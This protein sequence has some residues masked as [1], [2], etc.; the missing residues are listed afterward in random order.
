MAELRPPLARRVIPWVVGLAF[1]IMTA[2]AMWRVVG[3]RESALDR[4]SD[5]LRAF[6]EDYVTTWEQGLIEDLEEAL[7]AVATDPERSA[8]RQNRMRKS[9][10]WF[11]SLYVWHR[12]RRT[13]DGNITEPHFVFPSVSSERS[14]ELVRR[15]CIQRARQMTRDPTTD[16][17]EVARAYT[18]GCRNEDITVRLIA[19]TEAAYLLE[20]AGEYDHAHGALDSARLPE[21]VTLQTAAAQGVPPF[22]VAVYRIARASVLMQQRRVDAALDLLYRTGLDITSLDA[23]DLAPCKQFVE[24]IF[25]QLRRGGRREEAARLQVLYDRADRRV[26]A[27][28]EIADRIL[29]QPAPPGPQDPKF[30]FDQYSDSPFL[31]FY[32][33]RDELGVALQL[34]QSILI[35]DFLSGGMTGLRRMVTITDA[36]GQYVAGARKGGDM[37]I[38]VPF[39]RTLTHLR[40]GVRQA[41]LDNLVAGVDDQWIL[42]LIVISTCALLGLAALWMQARATRQQYEL[43]NRQRAFTTRVTHELKTP[44]AGI[45]VMA[46]NLEAGAFRGESQRQMMARRIVEEA[47][48]LTERVDEVLSVARA[49][50]IPSPEPFDPEEAV[51]GAIDQ[52]GPRLERV[53]VRLYADLHP[54]DEVMGDSDALRDAVGCLLDNA[55]K[56]RDEA[57][58]EASVWLELRQEGRHVVVSVADNGIGVPRP[59]RKAI[60]DRFVRV[61]GPNRGKSGGHG[62]GLNQVKQ[63]VEAHRGQILCLEGIEGGAKFV[64]KL[65]ADRGS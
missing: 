39:S 20:V 17:V 42:P 31:L 50:E 38:T 19:A 2:I 1:L 14:K 45:K 23:P 21:Q 25:G 10:A 37:P 7:D 63:I 47:D 58:P 3:L 44:L 51:L 65:P 40:V 41:A 49:R 62:L 11:N 27:Y 12:A 5:R 46:E 35:T 59:M 36:S 55:L 13:S 29:T 8:M 34:E 64:V 60:F 26:V 54:T 24:P 52:W 18:L 4:E 61:E 48:R 6:V 32:G 33:W 53:G 15:P 28:R 9:K 43:M 30:V 56:Y 22:R 16:A 57:R